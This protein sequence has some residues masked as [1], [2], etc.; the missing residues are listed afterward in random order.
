MPKSKKSFDKYAY[1]QLAVQS[2]EDHVHIFERMFYELRGR[3]GL[4]LR[5]DF[6]GTG[7]ISC[8]WVKS[9]PKRTA[10][11]LDLDLEPLEYGR[12]NHINKLPSSVRRRV[13]TVKQNVMKVTR[14][15]FDFIGA[16]NFSFFVFK[17]R[18][19]LLQYFKAALKSLNREGIFA[20]ELA[21]GPGFIVSEREQRTYRDKKLGKCV[22]YWDQKDF[23]PVT[24]YGMYAIH[25]KTEDGVMHRDCFTYDWRVWT[26]PEL[27]EAMLEAGFKAV[28]VY[29][30][31]ADERGEGTGEFLRSDSGENDYSWIAFVVGTK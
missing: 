9:N 5:E 26:I 25:F 13:K 12:K 31:S 28:H 14:Q 22:Y 7:L 4:S 30:E 15:K 18:H 27:K 19:T 2:P 21:G 6:C 3:Q 24:H 16:G 8:E 17:D 11:G 20:L 23:D 10:V 1:Y 29:W